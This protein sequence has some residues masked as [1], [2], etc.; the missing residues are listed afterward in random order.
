MAEVQRDTLDT[1][2]V[3]HDLKPVTKRL[4]RWKADIGEMSEAELV[5]A[6]AL[7]K[8]RMVE[9]RAKSRD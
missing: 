2:L 6:S 3:V 9:L 1:G 7:I 5:V 4:I 8:V